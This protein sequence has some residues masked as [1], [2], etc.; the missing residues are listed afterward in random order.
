MRQLKDYKGTL[1][2]A[3]DTSNWT[4]TEMVGKCFFDVPPLHFPL[5]GTPSRVRQIL[6][7][8]LSGSSEL[9]CFFRDPWLA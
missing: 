5:R 1:N 9:A 8:K 7:A 3:L 4:L 2:D 6:L